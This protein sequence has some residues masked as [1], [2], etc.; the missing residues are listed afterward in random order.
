MLGIQIIN[1]SNSNAVLKEYDTSWMKKLHKGQIF[2]ETQ[3]N[4][5]ISVLL[6][7]TIIFASSSKCA[8]IGTM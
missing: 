3:Q 7:W 1:F 2:L 8:Y 5:V 4:Y 6:H